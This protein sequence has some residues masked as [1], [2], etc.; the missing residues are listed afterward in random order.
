MGLILV[1]TRGEPLIWSLPALVVAC[2]VYVTLIFKL[3]TFSADDLEVAREGMGFV[4]PL[5]TRWSNRLE[6]TVP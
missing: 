1:V 2:A 4:K 3:G 6:E 5:L